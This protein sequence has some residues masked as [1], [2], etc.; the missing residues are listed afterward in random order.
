MLIDWPT[1]LF[2]IIN[3]LI[4]LF[5]LKRFLYGP[6]TK[7]MDERAQ[8][9]AQ[10]YAKAALAQKA[11][12]QQASLLAAEREEVEKNKT[13]MQGQA[14]I[15]IE[16]WKA[17]RLE[18][19]QQEISARREQ[20]QLGLQQE[21]ESLAQTL[22]I[23]LGKQVFSVARKVLQDLADERLETCLIDHVFKIVADEITTT[24]TTQKKREPVICVTGFALG[25]AEK[26]RI[27]EEC[28]RIFPP[29][30]TVLFRH[31]PELGFGIRLVDGNNK[32]EWNLR[33]YMNDMEGSLL[34]TISE[35][36]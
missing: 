12:E 11:A 24:G 15:E 14:R 7:A 36:P 35:T 10:G 1:V 9:I 5:L 17:E 4:L 23:R 31:E 19:A 27:T 32:W 20:W 18:Q 8:N 29:P 26:D 33:H 2:Q 25:P 28:K 16:Q 6:I 30:G 3:F 22:K 34:K 21:Q 13:A